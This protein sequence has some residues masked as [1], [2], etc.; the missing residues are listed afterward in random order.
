M[1]NENYHELKKINF[2]IPYDGF[3]FRE[4]ENN[5]D[6][7]EEY[8]QDDSHFDHLHYL[9]NMCYSSTFPLSKSIKNLKKEIIEIEPEIEEYKHISIGY[10]TANREKFNDL[11]IKSIKVFYEN[12]HNLVKNE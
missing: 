7:N 8:T 1:D 12:I 11:T 3:Y 4:D 9:V 6:I 2:R 5:N 10:I